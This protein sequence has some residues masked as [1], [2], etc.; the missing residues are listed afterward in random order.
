MSSLQVASLGG[1]SCPLGFNKLHKIKERLWISWAFVGLCLWSSFS[2]SFAW[3][4]IGGRTEDSG[5]SCTTAFHTGIGSKPLS[6]SDRWIGTQG[7]VAL[8]DLRVAEHFAVFE[9]FVLVLFSP[10][11]LHFIFSVSLTAN[12]I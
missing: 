10:L 12:L 1:L 3:H 8:K 9:L 6:E 11:F 2:L 7:F 5:S 4:I